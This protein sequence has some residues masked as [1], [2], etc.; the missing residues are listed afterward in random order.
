MNY[1]L[2]SY[3]DYRLSGVPWLG[4]VPSHWEVVRAKWLF[5]RIQRPPEP[6]DEVVTCFRDGVVTLRR[7]RRLEGFTESIKEIGYQRVLPGDLVIHAMDAFCGAV[8]VSDSTGKCTPVYSVCQ[9]LQDVSPHYYARVVREMARTQWIAA[10]AKGI[11]ERSSDFRFETFAA[12]LVPVPPRE[13]QE[14]IRH[15]LGRLDADLL[16]LLREYRRLVGAS[17]SAT[18]RDTSLVFEYHARVVADVVTGKLDV[19]EAAARLPDETE[20]PGEPAEADATTVAEEGAADD[21][22]AAPEDTEA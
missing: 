6:Q 21:L 5:R 1:S 19:C 18:E 3:A 12:Q 10:L 22:H 16:R 20:E 4:L 8:G 17:R 11:R 14:A 15:F 2:S 13:E 9:P 7:N